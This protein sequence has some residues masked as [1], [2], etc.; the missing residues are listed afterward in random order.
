MN[1]PK[2][3][4]PNLNTDNRLVYKRFIQVQPQTNKLT[5]FIS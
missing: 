4:L 3:A 5:H 2:I 1:T